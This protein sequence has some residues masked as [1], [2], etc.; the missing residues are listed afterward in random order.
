MNESPPAGKAAPQHVREALN[1]LVREGDRM[2]EDKTIQVGKPATHTLLKKE[3]GIG[4]YR[5][6]DDNGKISFIVAR[7]PRESAFAE[8]P[9]S[10]VLREFDTAEKAGAALRTWSIAREKTS[11]KEPVQTSMV[12]PP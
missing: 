12:F 3:K 4:V 10:S 7:I 5:R 1:R 8:I 6:Q 11:V 9:P 2:K